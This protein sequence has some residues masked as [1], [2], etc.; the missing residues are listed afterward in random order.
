MRKLILIA[1]LACGSLAYLTAPATAAERCAA[2]HTAPFGTDIHRGIVITGTR[3]ECTRA[4]AFVRAFAKTCA[5][6]RQT[7][8]D[9]SFTSTSGGIAARCVE[10]IV[11]DAGSGGY[12]RERCSFRTGPKAAVLTFYGG[13]GLDPPPSRYSDCG[14]PTVYGMTTLV[15]ELREAGTTCPRARQLSGR[16][17][18]GKGITSRQQ[19][20]DSPPRYDFLIEGWSCVSQV[21]T[22]APASSVE[23]KRGKADVRFVSN[24]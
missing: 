18:L 19:V 6:R 5:A 3:I 15:V 20:D 21:L 10:V 14:S 16:I 23:C 22:S 7:V 8:G 13:F 11:G 4:Q 2:P 9:C 12:A 17:R 1:V 24:N